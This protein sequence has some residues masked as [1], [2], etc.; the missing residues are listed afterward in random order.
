VASEEK[1]AK[2]W[3]DGWVVGLMGEWM[4]RWLYRY[5]DIKELM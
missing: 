1:M 2:T 5:M 4:D 3:M